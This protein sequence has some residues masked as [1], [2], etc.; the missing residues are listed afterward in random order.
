M[1]LDIN[2]QLDEIFKEEL[3]QAEVITAE[4]GKIMRFPNLDVPDVWEVLNNGCEKIG[5][6]IIN[7]RKILKRY[8][9]KAHDRRHECYSINKTSIRKNYSGVTEIVEL[10]SK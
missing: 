1:I 9:F 2:K 4:C 3:L 7:Y 10:K 5:G 6:C 8:F